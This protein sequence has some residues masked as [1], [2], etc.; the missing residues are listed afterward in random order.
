MGI[1]E[2]S[3][4]F[5]RSDNAIFREEDFELLEKRLVEDG[6]LGVVLGVSRAG[7]TV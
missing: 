2:T 4:E 1:G 7:V 6:L 3:Y 5:P